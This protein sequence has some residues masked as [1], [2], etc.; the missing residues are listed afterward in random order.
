VWYTLKDFHPPISYFAATILHLNYPPTYL[1]PIPHLPTY[2]PT[3]LFLTFH[4]P[5]YNLTYLFHSSHLPSYIIIYLP[6]STNLSLGGTTRNVTPQIYVTHPT[7]W[8]HRTHIKNVFHFKL[9]IKK[10]LKSCRIITPKCILVH[11]G[12]H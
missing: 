5:S 9:F 11:S 12:F 4:L 2:L 3:Y 1:L 6:T 7:L 10:L 8:Q